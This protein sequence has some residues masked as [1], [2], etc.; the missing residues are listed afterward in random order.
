[1][2]QYRPLLLVA[3]A[4][5]LMLAAWVIWGEDDKDP[6]DADLAVS[7][8]GEA[9]PG[10]GTEASELQQAETEDADGQAGVD[11]AAANQAEPVEQEGELNR[12]DAGPIHEPGTVLVQVV[13]EA[14]TPV[15]GM[16]VAIGMQVPF[17]KRAIRVGSGT[18][19]GERG[20][21]ALKLNMDYLRREAGPWQNPEL[22]ADA[23]F[24]S[25][26]KARIKF[27]LEEG[28]SEV[29]VLQV[30]AFQWLNAEVHRA[31]GS[32]P[33]FPCSLQIYWGPLEEADNKS[34]WSNR[35][36]IWQDFEGNRARFP[37][38]TDLQLW[39]TAK[40]KDGRCKPGDLR[41]VGPAAGQSGLEPFQLTLGDDYPV[42][43]SQFLL[44]DGS[45]AAKVRIGHY[46]QQQR[47]PTAEEAAAGK[48]PGVENTH[49]HKNF[50]TDAEGWGSFPID[51]KFSDADYDRRWAF[52]L[53]N[54]DPRR[55]SKR[56]DQDGAEQVWVDLPMGLAAGEEFN[57]GPLRL[58]SKKLPLLAGGL[59]KDS[60]GNPIRIYIT[61]YGPDE[62]GSMRNRLANKLTK[63]DGSFTI[64]GEAPQGG[65]IRVSA[66]GMGFLGDG[67]TVAAGTSNLLFQLD[68]GINLKG[69]F[70]SDAPLPWL[71]MEVKLPSYRRGKEVFGSFTF[72]YLRPGD[73]YYITLE[74]ND[75]ELYRGPEFSLSGHGDQSPDFLN[76][77]DIRGQLRVWK[78]TPLQANGKPF[79]HKTYFYFMPD[80]GEPNRL[81]TNK[82]GQIIQ[83]TTN[84]VNSAK[85]LIR[86]G[87]YPG[88][89]SWPWTADTLQ[90]T[91]E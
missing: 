68:R 4:A 56:L 18:S 55:S 74:H 86:E 1:M 46:S 69:S 90:M 12:V 40:A 66:G 77:I 53:Q 32:V 45:P 44:A 13:D 11:Q 81:R 83:V 5:L 23:K 58:Q 17:E 36:S 34:P 35:R 60:D 6:M 67:Q 88:E 84:D 52:V 47:N 50:T 61:V 41:T 82:S 28:Q 64:L 43:R 30:P 73:G 15:E 63:R 80:N 39:L 2:R 54:P 42:F 78:T 76:P 7:A 33:D 10:D 85:L 59:V 27:L 26:K 8:T 57:P 62:K 25:N 29:Q 48:Y 37:C 20:I 65:Q 38:G 16:Q 72:D 49:W 24:P 79:P 31:D 75:R 89:M 70:K 3:A 71:D 87:Y 19:S 22:M 9:S 91:P 14:G 21:A 51:M